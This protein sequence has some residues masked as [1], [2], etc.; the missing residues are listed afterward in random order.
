[1]L[2]RQSKLF[3]VGLMLGAALLLAN[4]ASDNGPTYGVP[5]KVWNKLTP[6]QRQQIAATH[7]QPAVKKN[8]SGGG[9][10]TTGFVVEQDTN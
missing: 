4:C 8:F 5:Q 9:Y 7:A 6:E 2:M 1:M 3:R 10:G